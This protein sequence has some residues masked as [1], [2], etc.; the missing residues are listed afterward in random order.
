MSSGFSESV[1]DR[2]TVMDAHGVVRGSGS[3]TG[4]ASYRR[5][6]STARGSGNNASS[7]GTDE[8]AF[9]GAPG[10]THAH[11]KG[12][13]DGRLETRSRLARLALALVAISV[14]ASVFSLLV[15][16]D[17][18]ID[19]CVYISGNATIDIDFDTKYSLEDLFVEPGSDEV[20]TKSKALGAAYIP[21]AL[22]ENLIDRARADI[23]RQ[24]LNPENNFGHIALTGFRK[25]HPLR[26]TPA[27][28]EVV[29]RTTE[30]LRPAFELLG[31]DAV[32]VELTGNFAWP[33]AM[34][35]RVHDDI[36]FDSNYFDETIQLT[37]FVYLD[38]IGP[39]QGPTLF[40]PDEHHRLINEV[41]FDTFEALWG[42]HKLCEGR[43]G[44]T[45][46]FEALGVQA[47]VPKG[48]VA[49]YNNNLIH[50]GTENHSKKVR[51]AMVLTYGASYEKLIATQ[52]WGID[53]EYFNRI[54]LKHVLDTIDSK[55]SKRCF[56]S[57]HG[58][59]ETNKVGTYANLTLAMALAHDL[60]R[61]VRIK[62]EPD[63]RQRCRER[64]RQLC[65][66]EMDSGD[67][68][69]CMRCAADN[70]HCCANGG[71]Y[72]HRCKGGVADPRMA[73]DE[74][75]WNLA[76]VFDLLD[77]YKDVTTDEIVWRAQAVAAPDVKS[78]PL[79]QPCFWPA[80][81]RECKSVV[82][83]DEPYAK[84]YDRLMRDE[85]FKMIDADA[86]VYRDGAEELGLLDP[87]AFYP[88]S[89]LTHY[90]FGPTVR[91]A[92]VTIVKKLIVNPIEFSS[93]LWAALNG[94]DE[95]KRERK[96]QR[97]NDDEEKI[98]EYDET[99]RV[100][101]LLS[102]MEPMKSLPSVF[103]GM[104]SPLSL[105]AFGN[106]SLSYLQQPLDESE[107]VRALDASDTGCDTFR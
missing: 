50:G 53:G 71:V 37:A 29:E 58:S 85:D 94:S 78:C 30:M 84:M 6:T 80:L 59:I 64:L 41:G 70:Y 51:P 10:K 23:T 101:D 33:G 42:V 86:N 74:E 76:L 39:R 56:P 5:T 102:S 47:I 55:G 24:M 65:G 28:M 79:N 40:F 14:T 61:N 13:K 43:H 34:P 77:Q 27:I 99:R 83:A 75:S 21:S 38:D 2:K 18:S 66:H 62:A 105:L 52:T 46:K 19:P 81:E 9:L 26:L 72:Q 89:R 88:F 67:P 69:R 93:S 60:E 87:G 17:R 97:G 20:R 98:A 90:L 36:S 32:I 8:D 31:D 91:W 16:I 73:F 44:A 4:G 104:G 57:K 103:E 35:Q 100:V 25:E 7:S 107:F 96:R 15:R 3:L 68:L 106:Y 12:R 54:T 95:E 92:Y 48:T 22:P 49:L 82:Y 63:S 1:R 11:Q 45:G